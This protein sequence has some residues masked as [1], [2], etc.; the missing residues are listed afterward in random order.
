MN[1]NNK[2]E[3]R[4]LWPQPLTFGHQN[5]TADLKK[6][7]QGIH[8]ISVHKHWMKVTM[9]LTSNQLFTDSNCK[10][11]PNLSKFP[12]NVLYKSH[13]EV[14]TTI[15]WTQSQCDLELWPLT[16]KIYSVRF[17]VQLASCAKFEGI[18]FKHFLVIAF[19]RTGWLYG[20]PENIMPLALASAAVDV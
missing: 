6:F 8:D 18:P 1:T 13:S 4:W 17:W 12:L 11:V 5:L 20:Q 2:N 10:F 7:P 3:I 16:T 14:W 15:G 19:T 9:T